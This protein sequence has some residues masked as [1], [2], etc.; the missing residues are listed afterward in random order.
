[1]RN[2]REA[3][4]GDPLCNVR[5]NTHEERWSKPLDGWFKINVDAA[6]DKHNKK[7]GLGCIIRNSNGNFIAAQGIPW[8]GV[9]SSK[10]AEAISVR[11][12]L[13]WL[14]YRRMDNVQLEMDALQVYQNINSSSLSTHFDLLMNDIRELAKYFSNICFMFVKRSANK[15]AHII[16]RE[17]LSM[18]DRR[19]WFSL[20]L[21]LRDVLESDL[22]N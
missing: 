13:S 4:S 20:P 10:E 15:A 1:M 17:A 22:R 8:K 3:N 11:E 6:I 18:T 14:K 16:A 2:W 7:M 9:Y 19:E 12:A 5:R 21:S